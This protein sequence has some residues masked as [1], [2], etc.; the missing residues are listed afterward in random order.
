MKRGNKKDSPLKIEIYKEG[1]KRVKKTDKTKYRQINRA[2][3]KC[4]N[5]M[6]YCFSDFV[7]K[8]TIPQYRVIIIR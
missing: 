3:D 8:E 4:K 6:Y 7:Q 5:A 1:P 2:G